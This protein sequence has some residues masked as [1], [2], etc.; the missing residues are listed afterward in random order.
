MLIIEERY[1]A[2]LL[3][4]KFETV[5]TDFYETYYGHHYMSD[6]I[7]SEVDSSRHFSGNMEDARIFSRYRHVP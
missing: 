7:K 5:M 6:H 1:A 3:H 2:R 4:I